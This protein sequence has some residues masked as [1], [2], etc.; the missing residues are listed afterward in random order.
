MIQVFVDCWNAIIN[1]S[2]ATDATSASTIILS[3]FVSQNVHNNL[4]I[5]FLS[6]KENYFLYKHRVLT[7]FE[8][9]H[10]CSENCLKLCE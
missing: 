3:A 2:L 1:R 4:K 8:E 7:Q 6:Y 9:Y 5:Q 10:C